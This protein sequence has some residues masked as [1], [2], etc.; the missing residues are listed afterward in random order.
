MF[1]S[2]FDAF[3]FSVAIVLAVIRKAATQLVIVFLNEIMMDC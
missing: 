2:A 3:I 1:H